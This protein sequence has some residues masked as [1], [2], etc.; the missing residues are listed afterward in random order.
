MTSPLT[1]F[2]FVEK[3]KLIPLQLRFKFLCDFEGNLDL[4]E[5]SPESQQED[6]VNGLF[7][8]DIL[9][10]LFDLLYRYDDFGE[11]YEDENWW[12]LTLHVDY[13]CDAHYAFNDMINAMLKCMQVREKPVS[14]TDVVSFRKKSVLRQIKEEVAFR[15]GNP[16][17]E[18][19]RDH[20]YALCAEQDELW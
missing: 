12:W 2:E 14:L 5:R 6:N 9:D 3:Y 15:P 20:F 18:N 13:I 10:D 8:E 4:I 11:T 7:Y 16:G 1:A 17:F 19:S